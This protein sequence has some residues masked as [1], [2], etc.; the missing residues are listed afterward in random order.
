[1]IFFKFLLPLILF[2]FFAL[3]DEIKLSYLEIKE[4]KKDYYSLL[5]KTA[6][7]GKK[8]L[9]I[10]MLMPKACSLV[11]FKKSQLVN[12]NYLD[13]WYMKCNEGLEE[14][15]L[16]FEGL[17]STQTE[18]LLRIEFLSKL[19]HSILLTPKKPFYTIAKEESSFQ[20]IETYTWLGITHILLGYDH[21]LFVFGLLLLVKNRRRLLWVLTAFTLAHSFTMLIA[22]LGIVTVP[23]A[24][25]EAIIA[26]SI[27]FLSM[28]IMH[29]KQGR[30]GTTAKYPW[31]IAFIFGL[32]HGFGFAGALAEIGLP[33]HAITLALI[34]FNVGVELGQVIFV[35]SMILIF[36][37][38]E[39]LGYLVLLNRLKTL[40]VYMM[41]SLA[42]FWLIERV[43]SF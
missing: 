21:I 4:K 9:E 28:E 22:T 12:N 31:L 19:S 26:L 15:T 3:A 16:F 20:I 5:L 14:K 2:S 39:S 17:E 33:E 34:F 10:E 7:N 25:V 8:K 1:M 24:P 41:G 23:Q 11:S 13:F 38:L 43:F 6:S 27:L 30:V 35:I 37:L 32:L 42:S 29:E 18:L 40:L 36:K